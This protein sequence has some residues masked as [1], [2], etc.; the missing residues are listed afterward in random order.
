MVNVT[1]GPIRPLHPVFH[2]FIS[3]HEI[4]EDKLAKMP[5]IWL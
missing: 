5:H 4:D 3:L 2:A 1:S